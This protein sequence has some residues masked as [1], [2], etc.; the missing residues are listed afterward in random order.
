MVC[1]AV[2]V[3][4]VSLGALCGMYCGDSMRRFTGSFVWYVLRLRYVPFHWELCV[5]CTA[6]TVCAVSL[7]SLCGM[8]CGDGMWRFTGSFVWYV[9]R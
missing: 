6:V 8:Y 9:L 4:A 5:V 7:G 2:T 1:T 3:C